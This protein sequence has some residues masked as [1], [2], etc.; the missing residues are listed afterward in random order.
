MRTTIIVTILLICPGEE[1]EA[2]KS[3]QGE[4]D[5]MNLHTKVDQSGFPLLS[6]SL[7]E[8][9]FL[10][11]YVGRHLALRCLLIVAVMVGGDGGRQVVPLAFSP[12]HGRSA[13]CR[14]SHCSQMSFTF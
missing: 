8:T 2:T 12:P 5:V 3:W 6:V 1:E 9:G 11:P 7:C 10:W 14:F 4:R 13:A